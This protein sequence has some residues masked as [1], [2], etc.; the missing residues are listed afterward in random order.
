MNDVSEVAPVSQVRVEVGAELL[1]DEV[2]SWL[3]SSGPDGVGV[4]TTLVEHPQLPELSSSG[5]RLA[6]SE[7]EV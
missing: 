2:H 4:Q 5:V 6:Q 7:D 3:V 1:F